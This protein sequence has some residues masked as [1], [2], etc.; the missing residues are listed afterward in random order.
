MCD[1]A[2]SNVVGTGDRNLK[3][4]E[5]FLLSDL[6]FI[7][8]IFFFLSA[9]PAQKKGEKTSGFKAIKLFFKRH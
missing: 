1:Y 3:R 8:I 9:V 5:N 4:N 2:A 7:Q 6:R